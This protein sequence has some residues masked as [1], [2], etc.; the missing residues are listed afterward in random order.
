VDIVTL[1]KMIRSRR[2]ADGAS[3]SPRRR[4]HNALPTLIP[5]KYWVYALDSGSKEN[6]RM[7]SLPQ[8]ELKKYDG[9]A[10]RN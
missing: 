10:S 9:E 7:K 4:D 6:V 3:G 8:G 1:G 5:R 2:L